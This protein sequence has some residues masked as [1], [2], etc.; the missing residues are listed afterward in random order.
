MN[1]MPENP[2]M[3]INQSRN[4][5]PFFKQSLSESVV[6]DAPNNRNL[7]SYDAGL[8]NNNMNG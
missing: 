2:N 3:S 7:F 6:S 4:G 1:I 8:V 5:I